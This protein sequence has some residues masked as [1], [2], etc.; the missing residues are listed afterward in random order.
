MRLKT[1]SFSEAPFEVL[2]VPI[3]QEYMS[4]RKPNVNCSRSRRRNPKPLGLM[5]VGLSEARPAA[6]TMRDHQH[7]QSKGCEVTEESGAP[8]TETCDHHILETV[9]PNLQDRRI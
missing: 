3:C 7:A 6:Q 9:R 5:E 1:S 8:Q 2:V 4:R